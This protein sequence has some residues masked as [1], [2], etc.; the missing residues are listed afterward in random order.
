MTSLKEELPEEQAAT[1]PTPLWLNREYLLLWGGQAISSLGSSA[2]ELAFPLLILFITQ[3]PAQAGIGGALRALAYLLLGLP[4]G[5]L[6]DR[7]DRKRAMIVC[8]TGRALALGSIPLALALNHLTLA[9]IYLVA[10]I[11]GALSV[12]FGLANT[13]ALPNVVAKEQ[14]PAATAQEEVTQGIVTLV[15]PTLSG[16]L[17]GVTRAL[18]FL[19]DAISYAASVFSLFWIR[20]PFQEE[21]AREPHSLRAEIWEGVVWLWREPVA[22]ALVLLHGGLILALSGAS[23]LMIVIAQ[24]LHAAPAAIGLMFGISGIGAMLGAVLGGQAHKR[25]RLGQVL[26]SA[27]WVYVLLWPL[28]AIA[29]SVVALGAIL[30]A[31]WVVDE[32]Y[33][34][35][36]LSYRVALIPDALRGRVNGV[37][38]LVFYTCEAV[39]IALT[40]FLLQQ[41]GVLA[42]ILI[43]EGAFVLLAIAAT[44]NRAMRQARPLTDL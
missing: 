23:L 36:Q 11:E 18:P 3:S 22:R 7:W 44:L 4:A 41:V 30:A 1:R 33:D 10:V 28:F 2:S 35:V 29:P 27:F 42:T 9:Q 21:R 8:D 5:A 26:V 15:G 24:H 39:S 16:T 6:I 34:V 31:F 17:F 12:F 38:R 32:I 25:F 37:L 14:L 19:A 20:L 40:G 43:F 13:A